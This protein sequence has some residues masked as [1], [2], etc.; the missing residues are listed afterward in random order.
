M[1][2]EREIRDV[3][4]ACHQLLDGYNITDKMIEQ[5]LCAV[6]GTL[7]WILGFETVRESDEDI[8]NIDLAMEH[9]KTAAKRGVEWLNRKK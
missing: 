7:S 6:T 1:R 9:I 4:N 8:K 2:T 5:H 3:Y